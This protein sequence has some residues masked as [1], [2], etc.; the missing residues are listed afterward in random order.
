MPQ[1]A[2]YSPPEHEA[3]D[4]HANAFIASGELYLLD[5]PAEWLVF[6]KP[7]GAQERKNTA[8]KDVQSWDSQVALGGMY[9]STCALTIEDALRAVPGV[10]LVEVSAAAK[11]ARVVWSPSEVLPSQWIKAIEA[12]G[13]RAVPAQDA[14]AREVRQAQHRK[15]L[16]R[17]LLATFCMM[18]VMMYAWPAYGAN[19]DDL[20]M[21]YERLLRWAS[22]VIC[23]PML[24]F[25]CGPFFSS[26]LRDLK[27]RRISM[28][29]PVALGMLIT[30]V[31]SSI[32][33]LFPEG[34]FGHVRLFFAGRA[35]ARD[36]VA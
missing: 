6:S 22:W 13:Y 18:Q 21:E 1:D 26:A 16:W 24:I 10:Q 4:S 25:A 36:S 2:Q 32:G 15:A 11:R 20:L 23:I 31:V 17:W 19:P 33:T 34:I 7:Y 5:D 8:P 12:V 29:L 9:C 30:F 27:H 3:T 28:D 14:Q 35:L